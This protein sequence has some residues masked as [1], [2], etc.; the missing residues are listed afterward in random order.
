MGI[1]DKFRKFKMPHTGSH[2]EFDRDGK[3]FG[4]F[5]FKGKK[6]KRGFAYV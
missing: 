3:E 1:F 5:I 4:H 6:S 2:D